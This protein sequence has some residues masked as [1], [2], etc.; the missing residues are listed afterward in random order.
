MLAHPAPAQDA[1]I[2][3]SLAA[4]LERGRD[5]LAGGRTTAAVAEYRRAQALLGIRLLY[6]DP[7]RFYVDESV[8]IQ[9]GLAEAYLELGDPWAAAVEAERGIVLSE[10]DARLWT[11][12]GLARYRLAD[13][14]AARSALARAV[15]LD[16]GRHEA[17]WGLGLVAMAGNR[18]AE[19]RR[20]AEAALARAPR[21]RYALAAARWAVME[22]DY[23][24]AAGLLE[25]W[26]ALAPGDPGAE[27]G[28][29]LAA[30]YRA[31]AHAPAAAVD[32]GVTRAQVRFD[33]VPGDEVPLVPVRFGDRPPAYV[34]LDTGAER[35][36][37]DHDFARSIGIDEIWPGGPLEGPLVSSPGGHA[38]V[39]R[40][41]IGSFSIAR[42]P[43][44]VAD[45]EALNLGGR[46]PYYIAAVLNPALVFRDFAVVLDYRHRR[47]ELLRSEPGGPAYAE[48][49]TRLRKRAIPFVL[50]ANGVWPLVSARLD[51]SREIPLLVDTGASDVLLDRAVAGALRIDPAAVS[52][53]VGDH[54]AYGLRALLMDGPPGVGEGIVAHGVLGYPFFRHLRVVF[55]YPNATLI[56]EE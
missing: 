19:A 56:L 13:V 54:A 16:S 18:P 42:V 17:R 28:R 11:A 41:S 37:V 55:D 12:L 51:G 27:D 4:A 33:L 6:G 52:V 7:D 32:R 46:H 3:D 45:F 26:L 22:G 38:V 36:L 20:H 21:A 53:Q 23:G 44:A 31:V 40:L 1:G 10:N 2:D 24:A 35:N 50:D 30:F 39:E 49:T 43:F 25:R 8:T 5:R 9:A 48:R 29:R 47:L 15:E 14:G 34:M